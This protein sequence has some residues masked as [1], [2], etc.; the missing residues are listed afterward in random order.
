MTTDTLLRRLDRWATDMRERA[1]WH[2]WDAPS[3]RW[4]ADTLEAAAAEIR[5][6]PPAPDPDTGDTP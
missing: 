2:D 1:A 6:R 4:R 3:Y 5:R